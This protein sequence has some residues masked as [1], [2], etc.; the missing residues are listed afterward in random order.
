MRHQ[1][2]SRDWPRLKANLAQTVRSIAAQTNGDWRQFDHVCGSSRIVR[3]DLY[4][5]PDTFESAAADV[6]TD[7]LGS[8]RQ[9]ARLLAERG[10]PLSPLPFPAAI[11]R[12]G[13]PNSHSRTPRL[14]RKYVFNAGML[15]RPREM[16][17]NLFRLRRVGAAARRRAPR[18][19]L[20]LRS[21]VDRGVA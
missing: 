10:T 3:T 17:G 2:N 9:I 6:I 16:L 1:D 14:L 12:V 7:M 20:Y 4:R 15:R 18:L 11:Y 13:H 5:M 21:L 19:S 8:H